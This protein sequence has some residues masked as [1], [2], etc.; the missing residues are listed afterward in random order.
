MTLW[1]IRAE[2][3]NDVS[4]KMALQEVSNQASTWMR[5]HLAKRSPNAKRQAKDQY[6]YLSIIE[7][8]R[9]NCLNPEMLSGMTS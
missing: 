5:T 7:A 4:V 6:S 1:L 8:G 3:T 9:K 2:H